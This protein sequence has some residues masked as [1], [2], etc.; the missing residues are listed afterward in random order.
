MTPTQVLIRIT[1]A[2]IIFFSTLFLVVSQ[3]DLYRKL[4]VKQTTGKTS[5]LPSSLLYYKTV[6]TGSYIPEEHRLPQKNKEHYTIELNVVASQQEA[7]KDLAKWEKQGIK[8]YYTPFY[9]GTKVLYRV[10]KGSYST[11]HTAERDFGS[12]TIKGSSSPKVVKM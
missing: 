5:K 2:S 10:R 11:L 6:G 1:A 3:L 4:P 7:I 12:L 8:A 9:D